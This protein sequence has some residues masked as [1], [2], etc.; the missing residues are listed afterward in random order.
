MTQCNI[1]L[2]YIEEMFCSDGYNIRNSKDSI[3]ITGD[4][5]VF[6]NDKYFGFVERQIGSN[7]LVVCESYNKLLNCLAYLLTIKD[8]KVSMKN[9]GYWTG[10]YED[11]K[12][13]IELNL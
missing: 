11:I 6:I 1:P 4:K 8:N 13:L 7:L 9:V 10:N 5:R 2:P 12:D 3:S